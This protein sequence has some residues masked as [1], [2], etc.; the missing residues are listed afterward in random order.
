[1][2]SAEGPWLTVDG[3]QS[4]EVRFNADA[5]GAKDFS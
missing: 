5:E 4:G 2:K 3:W 1:M